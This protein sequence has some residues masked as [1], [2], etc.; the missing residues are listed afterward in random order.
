[1]KKDEKNI[2]SGGKI[3]MPTY[4]DELQTGS[5]DEFTKEACGQPIQESCRPALSEYG[6]SSTRKV[7]TEET[8]TA[9]NTVSFLSVEHCPIE[10]IWHCQ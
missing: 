2:E 1:M 9:E 8:T 10:K 4:D 5:E 7:L 6:D 3:R